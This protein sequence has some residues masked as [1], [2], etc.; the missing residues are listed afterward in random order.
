MLWMIC[1]GVCFEIKQTLENRHGRTKIEMFT[2]NDCAYLS[3]SFYFIISSGRVHPRIEQV[4]VENTQGWIAELI[5]SK[6]V[7][8]SFLFK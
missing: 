8:V 5:F 2:M 3:P 1:T 7:N 6:N 4:Q